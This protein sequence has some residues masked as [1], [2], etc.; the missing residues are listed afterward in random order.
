[1]IIILIPILI[2]GQMIIFNYC[3][4]VKIFSLI[5]INCFEYSAIGYLVLIT[6]FAV[7]KC[8]DKGKPG[9]IFKG[10][11]E[12]RFKGPDKNGIKSTWSGPEVF[13]VRNGNQYIAYQGERPHHR[14]DIL[15]LKVN[16]KSNTLTFNKIYIPETDKY[17]HI[18][19][20]NL[21][22]KDVKKMDYFEGVETGD[23]TGEYTDVFY[24]KKQ[25]KIRI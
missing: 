19:G 14:F 7:K 1:M 9:R 3:T 22:I 17:N 12:K 10:Q 11:W 16:K 4:M 2:I 20:N 5:V 15:N 21:T 13:E 23:Y 18:R 24:I 8:I 6:V 25:P